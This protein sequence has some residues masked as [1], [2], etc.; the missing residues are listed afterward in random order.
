ML[1]LHLN[2]RVFSA[3]GRQLFPGACRA[4]PQPDKAGRVSLR[5]GETRDA[6]AA[7]EAA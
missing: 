4:S 7:F 5:R 3:A 1:E 6:K 2:V